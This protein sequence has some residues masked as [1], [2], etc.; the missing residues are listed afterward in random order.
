[1]NA[2]AREKERVEKPEREHASEPERSEGA[3]HEM[4]E[5]G[6]RTAERVIEA[7]REPLLGAALA[8]TAVVAIA[9]VWGAAEAAVGVAGAY[10]V[11]RLLR[12][13]A[14]HEAKPG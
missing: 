3:I 1:M 6:A 9:V 7:V 2:Q 13:R 10:C 4:R 8:G 12:R 5:K 14:T 11:Y